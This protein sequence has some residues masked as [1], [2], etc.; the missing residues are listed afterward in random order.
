MEDTVGHD[1]VHSHDGDHHDVED[2]PPALD[3]SIPD[4]E[5]PP[6]ILSRRSLLRAAGLLGAGAAAGSVLDT[7]GVAMADDDE[8][9]AP[10]V[11]WPLRVVAGDHHIHTQYSGDAI[12]RVVDQARH[13]RAYG[14]DWIVI[15]DHGSVAHA[16]IGVEKVNPDI[17]RRPRRARRTC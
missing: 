2:L 10:P 1:D 11:A 4:D 5:L 15:T 3:M 17:R 13:A 7:P 8:D 12:Y 14:L 9:N 16:K 6:H